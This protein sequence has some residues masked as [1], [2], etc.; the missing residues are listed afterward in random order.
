MLRTGMSYERV[1][2]AFRKQNRY[3]SEA[4][5]RTHCVWRGTLGF[6]CRLFDGDHAV[7][8]LTIDVCAATMPIC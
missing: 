5:P 8:Q 3:K 6:L 1:I 4:N 2:G 7:E